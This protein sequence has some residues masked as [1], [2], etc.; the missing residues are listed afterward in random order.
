MGYGVVPPS[1][2]GQAQAGWAAARTCS[3]AGPGLGMELATTA[4]SL[5]TPMAASTPSATTRARFNAA[6]CP[7]VQ[8]NGHPHATCTMPWPACAH[9]V[10]THRG[11]QDGT[12]SPS[13]L[14]VHLGHVSGG[15]SMDRRGAWCPAAFPLRCRRPHHCCPHGLDPHRC[16]WHHYCYFQHHQHH[17]QHWNAVQRRRC[18]QRPS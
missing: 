17:Q 16:C 10:C 8:K 6:S 1:P 5:A 7:H 12:D 18:V 2:A 3:H 15:P 14:G 4:A 9:G 13:Q 11:L